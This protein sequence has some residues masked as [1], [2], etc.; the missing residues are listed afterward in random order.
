MR[1]ITLRGLRRFEER[2][3]SLVSAGH[4][5]SSEGASEIDVRKITTG[6][7]VEK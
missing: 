7:L 2:F 1:G 5:K 3:Y 4:F 6:D